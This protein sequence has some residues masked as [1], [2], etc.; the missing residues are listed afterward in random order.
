MFMCVMRTESVT[1]RNRTL[2]VLFASNATLKDLD[3]YR[4]RQIKVVAS[5]GLIVPRRLL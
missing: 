2:K 1:L 5:A 3:K 4:G